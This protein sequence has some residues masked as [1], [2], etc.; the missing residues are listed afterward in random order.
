M[1]FRIL[2]AVAFSVCFG[3][4]FLDQRIGNISL[5]NYAS[6]GMIILA[7]IGWAS[8]WLRARRSGERLNV[9]DVIALSLLIIL[10]K[11][12]DRRWFRRWLEGKEV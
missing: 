7:L 10:A 8:I 3:L 9:G 5:S 1:K 4:L 2:Y 11:E 6:I 12:K